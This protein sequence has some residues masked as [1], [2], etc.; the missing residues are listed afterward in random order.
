MPTEACFSMTIL[1]LYGIAVSLMLFNPCVQPHITDEEIQPIFTLDP[2]SYSDTET[3]SNY[4]NTPLFSPVQLQHP[5]SPES[6]RDWVCL[7]TDGE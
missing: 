7:E 4:S 1:G 3:G 5:P 6:M 2:R